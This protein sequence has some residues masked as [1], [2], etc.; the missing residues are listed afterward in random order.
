MPV[1]RLARAGDAGRRPRSIGVVG[2]AIGLARS[3]LR[4]GSLVRAV[5]ILQDI[6][7]GEGDSPLKRATAP[8]VVTPVTFDVGGVVRSGDLYRPAASVQAGIVVVP[9]AAR[10]GK[11]DPR[12]RA[13]AITFARTGFEVLVPEFPG[14]RELRVCADD[15]AI[16]ADGLLALSRHRA[17]QGNR[18]VGLVAVSYTVGPS[19][20]ALLT[21]RADTS[22]QFVLAVGGYY[23]MEA[24][25]TFFTTG[26]Y[27]RRGDGAW[28][29]REPD[30]YAKW[31]FAIS[32]APYLDDPDDRAVLEA[33]ARRCLDDPA[34]D[35]SGLV[36]VLKEGGRSVWELL[37]NADPDRVPS[38]IGALPAGVRDQ[39]AALDLKRRDLSGL[40]QKFFVVHGDDDPLLPETGS[41]ELASAIPAADLFVL[42]SLQHVDP[43]PSGL[44]DK[45]KML[46]AM[47]GFL[48]E[49]AVRRSADPGTLESPFRRPDQP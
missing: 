26:C 44:V 48:R 36:A 31:V 10:L 13:L 1:H 38:L 9:G 49:G 11:D 2:L 45:L 7:A 34:A 18:T 32:N 3:A 43:G 16:V 21:P 24:A 28:R 22:C 14:F 47:S 30:P 46:A 17:S 33:L 20:L 40:R 23:D 37:G 5:R 41:G 29:R 12:L 8:P 19:V 35:V 6:E 42:G 4:P 25:I 27:R 39:I 15:S